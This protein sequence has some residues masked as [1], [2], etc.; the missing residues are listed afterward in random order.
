[1]NKLRKIYAKNHEN[2]KN[3]KPRV[4]RYWFLYE[5]EC[6]VIFITISAWCQSSQYFNVMVSGNNSN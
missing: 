1:M 3:S 4:Q 6:T 5:K 2:F